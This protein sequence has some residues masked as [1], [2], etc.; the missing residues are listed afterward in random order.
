MAKQPQARAVLRASGTRSNDDCRHGQP[1][2]VKQHGPDPALVSPIPAMSM[3]SCAAQPL[4]VLI[5]GVCLIVY[6]WYCD[7]PPSSPPGLGRT[8]RRA[9]I[10]RLGTTATS[11]SPGVQFRRRVPPGRP[12]FTE[13]RYYSTKAKITEVAVTPIAGCIQ[14]GHRCCTR[15][16]VRATSSA[17]ERVLL[18]PAVH[19]DDYAATPTCRCWSC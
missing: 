15:V 8:D 10:G 3:I 17:L 12:L 1:A 14:A 19:F 9:G 11:S 4:P 16:H 18:R 7:L 6:D 13:V 5:G 2:H